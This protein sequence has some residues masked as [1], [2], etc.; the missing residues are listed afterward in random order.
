MKTQPIKGI[1]F[2]IPLSEDRVV[3]EKAYF[4]PH[5]QRHGMKEHLEDLLKKKIIDYS[6][7]P[8]ASPCFAKEKRED[9]SLRLLI[10]Y[11]S[12]NKIS[13]K[14][15][16]YFPK[17]EEIFSTRENNTS[18]YLSG[19]RKIDIPGPKKIIF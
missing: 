8:Y 9:G 11:R 7:S 6:D 17:I 18:T 1:I 10:D 4:L 14:Y 12:L 19:G 5:H 15:E 3:S 16:Y 13:V 2:T